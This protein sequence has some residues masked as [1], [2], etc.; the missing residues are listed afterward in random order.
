[1]ADPVWRE[2]LRE[3]LVRHGL[4]PKYI[5][6]LVQ[7]LSDHFDDV[8]AEGPNALA[9]ERVGPPGEIAA[10]A[11]A[12]YRRQTFSRKHPVLAF[13]VM[14]VLVLPLAWLLLGVMLTAAAAL[15]GLAIGEEAV[16]S[17]EPRLVSHVTTV[18][19][20]VPPAVF[21][22]VFNRLARSNGLGWRWP[23]LATC[24]LAVLAG[25]MF[26]TVVAWG[27]E[28][29]DRLALCVGLPMTGRQALQSALILAVG[30]WCCWRTRPAPIASWAGVSGPD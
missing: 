24:V 30:T 11:A 10:A 16:A 26:F 27:P 4:P 20:L 5:E 15:F 23:M 25:A 17:I 12:E 7:E 29:E 22:V 2:Q 3:E 9:S 28:R 21:A 14:P 1:M 8:L 6:R 19:L 18:A 13:A